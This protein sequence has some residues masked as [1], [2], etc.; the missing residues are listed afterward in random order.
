MCIKV[1]LDG[2]APKEVF[3]DEFQMITSLYASIDKDILYP[4]IITHKLNLDNKFSKEKPKRT[5]MNF[6]KREY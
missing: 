2:Q 6:S 1:F 4:N 3:Y 5:S